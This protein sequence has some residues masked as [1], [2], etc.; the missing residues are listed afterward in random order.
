MNKV[1]YLNKVCFAAAF[2]INLFYLN[3]VCFAAAF[4]IN[5]CW[6]CVPTL[7]P[8]TVLALYS[9]GM[10]QRNCRMEA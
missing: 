9:M 1:F 3:K 10:K 6:T 2:V 4:V 7:P 8:Q 5:F